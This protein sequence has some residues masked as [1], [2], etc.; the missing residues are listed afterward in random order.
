MLLSLR[1]ENFALIDQLELSL[2]AGLTVLTGETGAGKSIILD[3]IDAVLGGKVSGR[4]IRTGEEKSLVEATFQLDADLKAWLTA[5]EIDVLDEEI[6]TCTREVVVSATGQRN[7]SRIN[8]V[9]VNKQQMEQL[10]D[11]LVEITAQGQTVQLGQPALQRDWLDSYGGDAVLKQR[12]QVAQAY[13]EYQQATQ[14]LERRRQSEQNRLQHLELFAYQLKELKVANL[15]DPEELS[16][17]EAEQNRL[18]YS[19]DLQQHSYQIYQAIYQNDDGEACA[20]LLGQAEGTLQSMLQYDPQLLPILDSLSQA[21]QLVQEAGRAIN[22]YGESIEADP[23]RLQQVQDRIMELKQVCRKYGPTL[24]DA[25]ALQA[26]LQNDLA[27]LTDGGQSLADLEAAHHHCQQVLG[28]VCAELT[29]LRQAAATELESRLVAELKPLAMDKVQFQVKL[30]P[31]LPSNAGA[32]QITYVFSPNPGEP[33]QPLTE[34]ASGG[35]MSRFLLALQAVFSQVDGTG[36]LVFDEIDTGVSGRVTQAIAD[37]LYQLG[38]Q[39]QVL[40]VTHQAI[41][42][43]MADHHWRVSKHVIGESLAIPAAEIATNGKAAPGN[44]APGKVAKGKKTKASDAPPHVPDSP[45][46]SELGSLPGAEVRTVVRITPLSAAERREELAQLAGGHSAQEAIAFADSLLAKAATLRGALP[47][48]ITPE[49]AVSNTT[50]DSPPE[51]V[52]LHLDSPAQPAKR[53]RKTT[54]SSK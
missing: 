53:P 52:T 6:L 15:A 26:K 2:G 44:T 50:S 31:C 43:A 22:A 9:L 23:Q 49:M 39:H 48:S 18:T 30:T 3:A 40:C 17:L 37:K 47:E 25:I 32:D 35:E 41:V 51:R 34:I 46:G 21:L 12:G 29:Q 4:T 7:R 45:S 14:A 10:R 5:Q 27:A 24:V 11:L 42:A 1:I 38:R 13:A 28:A 33:L 16:Q 20:D 36:T 8:G 54:R 19:V